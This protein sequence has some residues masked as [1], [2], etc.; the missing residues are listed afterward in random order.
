MRMMKRFLHGES[1]TYF[2]GWFAFGLAALGV[3]YADSESTGTPRGNVATPASN[4]EPESTS[5]ASRVMRDT[6]QTADPV[7]W[8]TSPT[9]AETS[10]DWAQ[11]RRAD[12]LPRPILPGLFDG[13]T[14]VRE[15]A[16]AD[17]QPV[18][19]L[20]VMH[21]DDWN[22]PQPIATGWDDMGQAV[23]RLDLVNEGERPRLQL[24][25]NQFDGRG[26]VSDTAVASVGIPSHKRSP[27]QLLV[28]VSDSFVSFWGNG[29]LLRRQQ[30]PQRP[31]SLAA[32]TWGI[33]MR[34]ETG[35]D[36]GFRGKVTHFALFN[37]VP[38]ADWFRRLCGWEPVVEETANENTDDTADEGPLVPEPD[39][40][41]LPRDPQLI[42]TEVVVAPTMDE[43]AE[44]STDPA[45][46]APIESSEPTP[47]LL[48]P[49]ENAIVEIKP[50]AERIG[51]WDRAPANSINLLGER[52]GNV[53]VE[54]QARP[55]PARYQGE[56][57]PAP[58]CCV[59]VTGRYE[60]VYD[61]HGCFL[62]WVYVPPHV[63]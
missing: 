42:E 45:P 35:E 40:N 30:I 7:L 46:A 60:P 32:A 8:W 61:M 36:Q 2:L 54:I 14:I 15:P 62:F 50:E 38:S 23:A 28:V 10:D 25:L 1:R 19:M 21:C 27:L 56:C 49:I 18:A 24:R 43:V 53:R 57:V 11:S 51:P 47:P 34:Q 52:I 44:Q 37:E 29:E 31:R 26:R 58:T 22:S 55:E 4:Q 20:L 41:V 3:L 13:R 17:S 6:I 9:P 48:E 63:R 16:V 33:G 5:D 39:P 12:A 59:R